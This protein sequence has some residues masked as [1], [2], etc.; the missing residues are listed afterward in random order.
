MTKPTAE[1]VV[2]DSLAALEFTA[3]T[4]RRLEARLWHFAANALTAGADV[5]L[6]A[7][8]MGLTLD[9]LRAGLESWAARRRELGLI[10]DRGYAEVL[11]LAAG[12][13]EV[14]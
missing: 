14:V 7:D 9:A 12:E 4:V 10:G 11:R 6:T 5:Q 2:V 8:A 13:G 3:D 1:Q